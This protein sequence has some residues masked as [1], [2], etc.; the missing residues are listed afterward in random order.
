MAGQAG[1]PQ[2]SEEALKEAPVC[3]FLGAG[4]SVPAGLPTTVGFVEEYLSHVR[5]RERLSGAF[6]RLSTLLSLWTESGPTPKDPIDVE[7]LL[8]SLS[9]ATNIHSNVAGAFFEP[10]ASEILADPALPELLEDLRS[11]IR[12]RCAVDPRKTT[13][14]QTLLGFI[15]S[16]GR[17]HIFST[18]YDLVME[19]FLQS[20]GYPCTD[21]FDQGWNPAL[22][23]TPGVQAC[24]YKLHG[25]VNWFA[26]PTGTYFKLPIRNPPE[27]VETYSGL[28]A[29]ALM[30]YPAQKLEYSGPFL[31]MLGRLRDRL[32]SSLAVVVVGYSFRDPHV[33]RIFAEAMSANPSLMV[34]LIG[35]H[36]RE[37]YEKR[38]AGVRVERLEVAPLDEL[39]ETSSLRGRIFPIPMTVENANA[40]LFAHTLPRL[41]EAV[42]KEYEVRQKD[43][44]FE[45][46]DYG[47]VLSSYLQAGFLDRCELIEP[48]VQSV[49]GNPMRPVLG[50]AGKKWAVEAAFRDESRAELLWTGF[51][52]QIGDLVSKSLSAVS[53]G[54]R[55]FTV[56]FVIGDSPGSGM[57][58]EGQ[59]VANGWDECADF[60]ETFAAYCGQGERQRWIMDR[61]RQLRHF[62]AYFHTMS[63]AAGNTRYYLEQRA[64]ETQALG[65]SVSDSFASLLQTYIGANDAKLASEFPP[66]IISAEGQLAADLLAMARSGK[67]SR[68]E[69][70]PGRRRNWFLDRRVG[71]KVP[72]EL[73]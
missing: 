66:A 23:E 53:T 10:S 34:I 4:S 25:S 3:I 21:G 69:I 18:N 40:F 36:A 2:P 31:E 44:R 72:P 15:Q 60:A 39:S 67:L 24:L 11:F 42:G 14:W 52:D 54:A 73:R 17:T 59:D 61:V 16:Y 58:F 56:R 19:T 47:E 32:K 65:K 68:N 22:F 5:S 30:L 70:H 8:E 50:Y 29:R 9:L 71:P 57:V 33:V 7:L 26:T 45:S 63:S 62:T 37:I 38:L 35:P 48:R 28:S 6:A 1:P 13:Y 41:F 49:S 64:K 55:N 27:A 43:L 12:E 46:V 51:L 20:Y